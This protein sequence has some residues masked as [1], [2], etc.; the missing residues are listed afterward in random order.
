MYK[1]ET[2]T[3]DLWV[4]GP[5]PYHYATETLVDTD[6]SISDVVGTTE[7]GYRNIT[8]VTTE[9]DKQDRRQSIQFTTHRYNISAIQLYAI[10]WASFPP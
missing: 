1:N 10:R 7:L 4:T 5:R 3:R 2:R 9:D 8:Q 6:K